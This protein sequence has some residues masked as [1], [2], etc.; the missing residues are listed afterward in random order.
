MPGEGVVEF[1][2][3]LCADE[4]CAGAVRWVREDACDVVHAI[5][6]SLAP[7]QFEVGVAGCF[8]GEGGLVG[9]PD[10]DQVEGAE[11]DALA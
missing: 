5:L 3:D 7:E 2:L 9:G 11:Q 6:G 4:S 8:A 1:L 10:D